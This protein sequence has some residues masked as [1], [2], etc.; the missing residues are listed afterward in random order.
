MDSSAC[1]LCEQINNRSNKICSMNVI[2]VETSRLNTNI[3]KFELSQ[4][5]SRAQLADSSK[6]CSKTRAFNCA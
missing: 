1:Q 4:K 3:F 2:F 5:E 6:A